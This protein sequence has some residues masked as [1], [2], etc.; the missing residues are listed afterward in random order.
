MHSPFVMAC[1]DIQSGEIVWK[2]KIGGYL[3]TEVKE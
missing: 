1:R 3:Y 2:T